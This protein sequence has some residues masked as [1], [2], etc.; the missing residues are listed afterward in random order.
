MNN[1]RMKNLI[2][3]PYFICGLLVL[4]LNDFYLKHEYG[5]FMTGKLSDFAGLLIFPLF[6]ATILPK[7]KKYI[8]LITGIGFFIWKLPLFTP[9][10]DLINQVPFISIYRVIDYSDYIAL[11][12]LPISHYLINRKEDEA[13]IEHSSLK[14]V[15]RYVLLGT[16]F[17]AFCATSMRPLMEIPKGTI[18]IG[19]SYNIKLPKD[20]VISSIKLLGYNCDFYKVDSIS[21]RSESYYQTD[22]IIRR[23]NDTIIFDTI[24]NVKYQLMEINPNKTK[25]TIINVTLSRKGQIQDWKELRS[26]SKR[27]DEWLK[28]NLIEKIK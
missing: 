21:Y 5:N 25:L 23:Y 16:A 19:E 4:V 24:A 7:T 1:Q 26:L 11:L 8:S 15:S 28:D 14:E 12:I 6:I 22:N 10:I 20:S 3:T 17:F 9:V 27:Y 13:I 18:Y 2:L